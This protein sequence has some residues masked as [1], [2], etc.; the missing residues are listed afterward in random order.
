MNFSF[1]GREPR[2]CLVYHSSKD[3]VLKIAY[4]IGAF[5]R[6]LGYKDPEQPDIIEEQCPEVFAVDCSV[7]VSSH[8]GYRQAGEVYDHWARVLTDEPL[9]RFEKL[10]KP[11]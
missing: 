9:P 4:R 8:G 6:A 7:V 10:K 1:D 2:R 11:P 3:N 5:D